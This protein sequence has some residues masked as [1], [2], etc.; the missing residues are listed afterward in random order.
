M[1]NLPT[2][3]TIVALSGALLIASLICASGVGTTIPEY[4]SHEEAVRS[5]AATTCTILPRRDNIPYY[6]GPGENRTMLGYLPKNTLIAVVG[7]AQ[8]ADGSLW[9]LILH[10]FHSDPTWVADKDVDAYGACGEIGVMPTPELILLPPT[11]TATNT[12]EPPLPPDSQNS[13]IQAAP[14]E[15]PTATLT[16]YPCDPWPQCAE[17]TAEPTQPPPDA[18]QPVTG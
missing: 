10:M 6:V 12:A 9:W 13:N 5:S 8:A 15:A 17:A 2:G 16:P 1:D 4:Q 7:K 11:A 18:T 14:I 3:C